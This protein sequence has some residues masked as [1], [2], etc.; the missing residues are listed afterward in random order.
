MKT[1]ERIA[2]FVILLGAVASFV[3]ADRASATRP[4]DGPQGLGPWGNVAPAQLVPGAR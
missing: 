1:F 4:A 2:L 3:G